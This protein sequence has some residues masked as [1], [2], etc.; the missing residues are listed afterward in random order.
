MQVANQWSV[1]P[2]HARPHGNKRLRSSFPSTWSPRRRRHRRSTGIAPS[3]FQGGDK[4]G[5]MLGWRDAFV[6]NA[7]QLLPGPPCRPSASSPASACRALTAWAGLHRV[8]P[9]GQ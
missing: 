7:A 8:A 6:A 4:V 1:D 2:G 3:R 9:E 5:S